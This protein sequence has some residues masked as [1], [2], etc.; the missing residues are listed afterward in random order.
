[1]I[2]LPQIMKE[3]EQALQDFTEDLFRSLRAV[4]PPLS[5][6]GKHRLQLEVTRPAA[7]LEANI[8]FAIPNYKMQHL[9]GGL[10]NSLAVDEEQFRRHVWVDVETRRILKGDRK[11]DVDGD[12]NVGMVLLQL[13]SGLVRVGQEGK[14]IMLYP[15]KFLLQLAKPL[16]RQQMKEE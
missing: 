13:E 14:D 12:G 8:H 11:V 10:Q 3:R 15:M 1:M 16:P 2:K 6:D 5:I 7:S 9:Q 4:F